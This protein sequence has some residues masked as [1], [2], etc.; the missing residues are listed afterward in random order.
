MLLGSKSHTII[1]GAALLAIPAFAD[2]YK[3]SNQDSQTTALFFIA[4]LALSLISILV[5]SISEETGGLSAYE[6]TVERLEQN[7]T[8]VIDK[9]EK[10]LTPEGKKA[11]KNTTKSLDNTQPNRITKNNLSL[12]DT[13]WILKFVCLLLIELSLAAFIGGCL[14]MIAKSNVIPDQNKTAVTSIPIP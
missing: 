8:P 2:L 13:Q 1:N 10:L 4:G 9:Y 6:Q 3:I 12:L 5:A 11:Y 7:I 14:Y